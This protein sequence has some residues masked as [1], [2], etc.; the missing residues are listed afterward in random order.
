MIRRYLPER[1][2]I[3]MDMAPELRMIVDET[4]NRPMRALWDTAPR[5]RPPWTTAT[6][7]PTTK[8]LHVELD[9]GNGMC[10]QGG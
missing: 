9:N 6:V 8:A 2:A 5:P 10:C 7:A 1:T 3:T 4:D